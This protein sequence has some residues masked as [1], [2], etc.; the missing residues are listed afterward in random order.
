MPRVTL[1][2]PTYDRPA[3][4]AEALRGCLDQT[5]D[6]YEVVVIDNGSGPATQEVLDRFVE[7]RLRVVRFDENIGL[8]PAYNALVEHAGGE[9][10]AQLG[11][12]DVCL[13]D[14]LART[15]AELDAHPEAGVAHGD[16]IVIDADGRETGRWTARQFGRRAL[17]DMLFFGGNHVISPTAAV[18]RSAYEACGG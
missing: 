6:D 1:G 5:Y 8:M 10:I 14:R 13:P 11:D 2:F 15:V 3:Y 12:D 17:L 16:A 9:I 7:P 4:L 18:R